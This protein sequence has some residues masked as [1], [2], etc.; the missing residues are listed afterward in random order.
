MLACK[1]L[2]TM[3]FCNCTDFPER[4]AR[5]GIRVIAKVGLPHK[6]VHKRG[7]NSLIL[8]LFVFLFICL[9]LCMGLESRRS[10]F[11]CVRVRLF[12]SLCLCQHPLLLHSVLRHHDADIA[13]AAMIIAPRAR[14]SPLASMTGF[15]K[16]VLLRERL[17]SQCHQHLGWMPPELCVRRSWSV[18]PTMLGLLKTS[19]LKESHRE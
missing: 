6:L 11:V 12:A 13:I 15:W 10:A 2:V 8:R 14:N 1:C 4:E 18:A 5:V 17:V 19:S 7:C 9:R 3:W 16:R